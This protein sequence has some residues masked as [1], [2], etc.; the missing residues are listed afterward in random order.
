MTLGCA[1]ADGVPWGS[2]D[3]FTQGDCWSTGGTLDGTSLGTWA[4]IFLGVGGAGF[5]V[6]VARTAR[7][8]PHEVQTDMED[9]DIEKGSDAKDDKENESDNTDVEATT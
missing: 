2:F 6:T 9:K 1:N 7:P 4:G 8:D 5:L 3:W